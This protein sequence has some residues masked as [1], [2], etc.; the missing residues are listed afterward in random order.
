MF[1]KYEGENMKILL[2]VKGFFPEISASGN[3]L[4]NLVKE[5]SQKNEITILSTASTSY[6]M[7]YENN[8]K[9]VKIA[10]KDNVFKKYHRL[11]NM[12]TYN[13]K[14]VEILKYEI[15]KLDRENNF[16]AIIAATHDEIVALSRTTIEIKKKN[17]FIFEKTP[18]EYLNNMFFIKNIRIKNKN[19]IEREIIDKNKTVWALPIMY[20]YFYTK[21]KSNKIVKLE[22]PMIIDNIKN[23]E[24]KNNQIKILYCGGLDK[25]IRN[26]Q[27]IME[28]FKEIYKKINFEFIL[29][30]YGNMQDYLQ[31]IS[32]DKDYKFLKNLGSKNQHECHQQLCE[33]DIIITIGNKETDIFP[34]KIFDCISTGN[35]IIHFSQNKKDQYYDYLSRYKMSLIIDINNIEKYKAEQQIYEFIEQWKYSKEK[36]EV[37]EKNYNECTPKYVSEILLKGL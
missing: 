25:K 27:K 13:K 37:I 36:Y 12:K 9:L 31:E 22:H 6:E 7:I 21:F 24:I 33:A 3:L 28:I 29:I 26:P 17:C 16:N 30:S 10:K 19:K 23:K 1:I 2:I 4:I 11:I 20:E 5:M 32:K 34:S 8:I 15:E 35:P 14:M 18:V